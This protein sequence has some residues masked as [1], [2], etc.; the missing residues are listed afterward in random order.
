MVEFLTGEW[1]PS[2][3]AVIAVMVVAG[4]PVVGIGTYV[5]LKTLRSDRRRRIG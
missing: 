4:V 3:V 1:V 2:S 5:V